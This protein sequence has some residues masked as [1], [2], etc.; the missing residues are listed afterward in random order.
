MSFRVCLHAVPYVRSYDEALAFHAKA[1]E[2]PWNNSRLPRRAQYY[3]NYYTDHALPGKRQRTCG[4]RMVGDNV[5]FR[6]HSTEVVTW[7][8]DGSVRVNVYHSQS[9]CAFIN[10]FTPRHVMISLH[11]NGYVVRDLDTQLATPLRDDFTIFADG[12]IGET[13]PAVFALQRINKPAAKRLRE[14][15]GYTAFAKWRKIMEPLLVNGHSWQLRYNARWEIDSHGVDECLQDQEM[16]PKFIIAS[17]ANSAILAN[18]YDRSASEVYRHDHFD[19]VQWRKDGR[20][21]NLSRYRV[22]RR[23]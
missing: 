5:V 6:L 15:V 23:A 16:W 10:N 22:M 21:V 20:W 7:R 13:D 9:T 19:T 2:K 8:P 4:V 12:T 18:I 3:P 14:E 11:N 1:A 17:I